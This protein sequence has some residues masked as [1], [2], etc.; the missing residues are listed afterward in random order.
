MRIGYNTWSMA[1]VPYST[2][3]PCLADIGFGAVA[4]SVVPAYQLP[5]RLHACGAPRA[6]PS[7]IWL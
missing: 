1:T 7:G 6:W 2:F 3:I 5:R 4:V